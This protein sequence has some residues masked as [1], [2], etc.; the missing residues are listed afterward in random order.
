VGGKE[1]S[2]ESSEVNNVRFLK[3]IEKAEGTKVVNNNIKGHMNNDRKYSKNVW[4]QLGAKR[5]FKVNLIRQGNKNMDEQTKIKY[6]PGIRLSSAW[7]LPKKNEKGAFKGNQNYAESKIHDEAIVV[8]EAPF[9]IITQINAM[10]KD[11]LKLLMRSECESNNANNENVEHIL[12]AHKAKSDLV[13]VC[14]G[15][16][17]FLLDKNF[18]NEVL[19]V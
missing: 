18:G 3:F 11:L 10:M 14:I 6:K 5:K 16:L 19:K 9:D 2:V 12:T 8:M 13:S 7:N 15:Q 17:G 4:K 1:S